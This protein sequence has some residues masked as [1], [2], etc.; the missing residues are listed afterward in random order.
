[1][2]R[3]I[4][5]R[6]MIDG[7]EK[8]EHKY[9]FVSDNKRICEA[10]ITVDYRAVY[11]ASKSGDFFDLEGFK[12]FLEERLYGH[13]IDRYVFVL[14]CLRKKTNDS[15]EAFCSMHGI[16]VK[17][18][19]WSIFREK[20]YLSKYDAQD[21][22]EKTLRSYIKR[23][24]GPDVACEDLRPFHTYNDSGVAKSVKDYKIVEYLLESVTIF[25]VEQEPYVY[26]G[27]VYKRDDDG[28]YLMSVIQSLIEPALIKATTIERIYRLLI[29][30][31]KIQ[32]NRAELNA[33]PPWWINFKNGM[34]DIKN[35]K[36]M[37]HDPKYLAINQIPH[38]FD[39]NAVPERPQD[40]TLMKFL[41]V[42]VPDKE[43]QMMLFE[44]MGYCMTRDTGFQ[45]FM[46][47]TG[48]A[49]TGK[50]Q[51]ISLIQHIVG[52]ENCSPLSIQD[53]T[54]RFYPSELYGKL[55]N[56]CADIKA[57]TLNDVS[58]LKK[59]TGEDIL[60]YERKNKD[61]SSF[62]SYAKLLFSA[63][64]IPLNM[65]EKSN[66]FYRRLLILS[67]NRVMKEEEKD[68]ELLTK[69][70]KET[71]YVIYLAAAAASRL[72][73]DGSFVESAN[74]KRQ[75]QD[76]YRAADSVKAFL[77][78]CMVEE[79]GYRMDRNS[80]YRLYEEYCEENGRTAHK[81]GKFYDMLEDKGYKLGRTNQGRYVEGLKQRGDGFTSAGDEHPFVATSQQ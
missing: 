59:A 66:A 36:M 44:Y 55:L 74:S 53:L 1:M 75:V 54:Q 77:D 63:N 9:I 46:I 23:F 62:R 78:E 37:R 21:E 31:R 18:S 52:E 8:E 26:Q 47:I 3:G 49:G 43:D 41:S 12:A 11:I 30:Q 2:N 51:I 38:D 56:A 48:E 7:S 72:Y 79:P 6:W 20:E 29:I 68:R 40:T 5:E 50:S 28:I 24:E 17:A 81:P 60:M 4:L 39:P 13:D 34:L 70:K 10:I 27:G 45:K 65:D 25:V 35:N 73:K 32:K 16:E 19:G 67:M 15:I 33:Y 42:S 57:G 71:G 58:N 22:L 80:M 64:K 69:L 76:L 61:P 14:C